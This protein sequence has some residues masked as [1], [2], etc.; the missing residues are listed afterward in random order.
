[1]IIR[2]I[3]L[4]KLG[5]VFDIACEKTIKTRG[6]ARRGRHLPGINPQAP[7]DPGETQI[8]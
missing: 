4:I 6:P 1:M 2:A 8:G 5:G 7:G 3:C